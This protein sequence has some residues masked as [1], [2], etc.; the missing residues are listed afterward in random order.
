L[1]G[2]ECFPDEFSPFLITWEGKA[3]LGAVA[4]NGEEF[5]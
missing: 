5:N 4:A 1:S 2:G 3:N